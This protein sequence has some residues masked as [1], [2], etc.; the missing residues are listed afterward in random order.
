MKKGITA[1]LAAAA[2]VL[3]GSVVVATNDPAVERGKAEFNNPEF[4]GG[5]KACNACH[6]DGNGLEEAG[7]KTSFYI[8]GEMQSTLEEAINACIINANRGTA[9]EPKSDA[10]QDMV[11]YIRSLS[12]AAATAPP[13]PVAPGY[14]P[15]PAT[16]GYG[17]RK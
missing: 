7:T 15:K 4:A 1:I 6:P 10:M 12:P 9:L 14:G 16:P 5:R 3:A 2:V 8:M 17:P 13:K 11:R